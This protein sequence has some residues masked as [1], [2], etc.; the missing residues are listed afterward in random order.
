MEIQAIIDKWK[1]NRALLASKLN[2][3]KG[4]FNNKLNANHSS[5]FSEKEL[6]QLKQVLIDM[7]NDLNE[8]EQDFNEAL[9]IVAGG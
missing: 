2:M 3:P 9:K 8:I 5:Q 4:T 7:G 6:Y 1:I